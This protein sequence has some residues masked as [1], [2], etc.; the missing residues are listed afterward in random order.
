MAEK[1]LPNTAELMRK[2]TQLRTDSEA[3]IV[4]VIRVNDVAFSVDP[5][6]APKDAGETI[7][8]ELPA[9]LQHLAESREKG[10]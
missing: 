7:E 6:V 5:G 4:I 1:R 10:R 3:L 2:A 8:S 9:L